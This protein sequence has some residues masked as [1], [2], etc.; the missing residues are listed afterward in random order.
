MDFDNDL[1][2]IQE[3]RDLVAR[4][5]IAAAQ[6]AAC[7]QA[8]ADRFAEAVA[9]ACASEAARLAKM[10][11]EETGY[12]N[13]RDKTLK[14]ILGSSVTWDYIKNMK[15]LGVLREDRDSGVTEIGVGVGVIVALIPSTNPTSTTM[16]KALIALKSGNAVVFSPHPGAR[17]C[18]EATVR[19]IR[20]AL[21]SA[22]APANL[23]DCV[24][25]P[26]EAGA[27]A[28]LRHRGVGLILATGGEAMVRA[29]YS[30]GNPALGVGA[31][32]AP[33]YIEK[34][35]DVAAAARRIVESKTFDNGTICASEQSIV[36]ERGIEDKVLDELVAQ[37]A[38]MLNAQESAR[39]AAVLR[40]P[41]GS[42]NPQM[43][44]KTAA[45]CARLAGISA[46]DGV[47][48]LVSRQTD[49]APDNPYAREKLCPVL[50]FYVRDGWQSACELCIDLLAN[51]GAGHT[52]AIH[53]ENESVIREFAMKKPVSRLLVNTPAALGGVGA[54]TGLAPAFTLGC[55]AAGGS[56]TSD[57]LTP[58][59]LINIRRLA[60]HN[61]A[62]AESRLRRRALREDIQ[63]A[64]IFATARG[65]AA[66]FGARREFSRDDVE[67]IA[68]EVLRR[69]GRQ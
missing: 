16:Y 39:L 58:L 5:K 21:G 57:N 30:S 63:E 19:V 20:E 1:R 29:A 50:A 45:E 42:M 62:V 11:V 3:A 46:P 26:T 4:A 35:A 55:G 66:D 23:V 24:G 37:G 41:N 61:E 31:G 32:N 69:M 52:M 22:G 12:G 59:H 44:G 9:R 14:N 48:V 64:G 28:L 54:T 34:S 53:S 56:A 15:T 33:A 60:R 67:A 2:S 6:Y 49:A 17:G 47:S 18:I 43:V 8:Q 51:E 40:R 65:Q 38:Y 25:T 7:D 13:A 68:W 36:T 27:D 10:A